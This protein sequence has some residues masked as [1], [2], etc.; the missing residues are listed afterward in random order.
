MEPFSGQSSR[1]SSCQSRR[2]LNVHLASPACG[3]A[4]ADSS[5]ATSCERRA[6]GPGSQAGPTHGSQHTAVLSGGGGGGRGRGVPFEAIGELDAWGTATW[7]ICLSG[8]QSGESV[9]CGKLQAHPRPLVNNGSGPFHCPERRSF[10]FTNSF[11]FCI[12]KRA[13]CKT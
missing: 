11:A 3:Q 13:C 12:T 6:L 5:G 4:S 10:H 8:I 9:S 7:R 1:C 2:D